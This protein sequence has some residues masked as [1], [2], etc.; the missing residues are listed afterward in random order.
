MQEKN[1]LNKFKDVL[2]QYC[3]INQFV[4]LAK[5][6]FVIDHKDDIKDRSSFISLATQNSITLTS[7]DAE[8]MVSAISKSYIVNVNLSFETFLKEA[9]AQV[10][11]YG[12]NEYKD[13]QQDESWLKCAV[14]NIIKEKLPADKQALYDLCEYYRLVRNSSVHDLCD[15]NEHSK[16]F[17]N[18]QK[19]NFK[20]EAKFAKLVAPNRYDSISFDDFVMFARSCVEFATYLFEN[21]S[22]DYDKIISDIPEPL[23][24]KWQRYNQKRRENAIFAYIN[25][26]FKIDTSFESQIPHLANLIAAQ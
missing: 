1:I 10:R 26:V 22:Y 15:V 3:A 4:E 24:S 19:Y 7:Y 17:N 9:C 8:T 6:C 2:G 16:E 21:I 18:L 25:T 5:R 14:K 11:K 23:I 20:T 13:K 12:K